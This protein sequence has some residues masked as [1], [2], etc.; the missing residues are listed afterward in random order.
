[1]IEKISEMAS[2]EDNS[3]RKT[4]L[5]QLKEELKR[6]DNLASL[7]NVERKRLK[8]VVIEVDLVVKDIPTRNL[9]ET[10]RLLVAAAHL[11]V[12]KLILKKKEKK[13]KWQSCEVKKRC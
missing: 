10:N 8:V 9:T 5:E 11:T 4:M 12:S 7:T 3:D 2:R 6:N 13:A 1:M